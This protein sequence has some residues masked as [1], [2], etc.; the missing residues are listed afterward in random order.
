MMPASWCDV[1]STASSAWSVSSRTIGLLER[2]GDFLDSRIGVERQAPAAGESV[3]DELFEALATSGDEPAAYRRCRRS[4]RCPSFV[5][6][7]R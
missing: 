4:Q 7:L 1:S 6:R 3:I 2:V 5:T